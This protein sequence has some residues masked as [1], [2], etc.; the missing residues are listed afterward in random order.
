MDSLRRRLEDSSNDEDEGPDQD[1]Q[2][3][4]EVVAAGTSEHGSKKG[5]SSK[6][7]YHHSRLCF[8]RVEKIDI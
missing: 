7:R 1:G 4:A 5:A 8:S 6:Q 3:P 2:S